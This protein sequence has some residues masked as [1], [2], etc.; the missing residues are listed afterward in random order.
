VRLLHNKLVE[1]TISTNVETVKQDIYKC[2]DE[3]KADLIN[4]TSS[5]LSSANKFFIQLHPNLK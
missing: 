4:N 2:K 5:W 1:R 3:V